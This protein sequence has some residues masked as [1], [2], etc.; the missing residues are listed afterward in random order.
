MINGPDEASFGELVYLNSDHP[1]SDERL[2]C[3]HVDRVN[4]SV[5]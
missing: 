2:R 4:R 1:I 3:V 5:I